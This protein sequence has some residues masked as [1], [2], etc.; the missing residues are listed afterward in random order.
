MNQIEKQIEQE[1][2]TQKILANNGYIPHLKQQ[3]LLDDKHRYKVI[4]CGRRFGKTVYAVNFIIQEASSKGGDYWFVAPTYRQAKEIAWRVFDQY[5]PRE[6]I[7]KKN[8]TEL[9]IELTN[10]ARISLKGA[11]NPDSLR[12]VG[13]NGVVLDEYAFMQPYAW[14]VISPILQDKKGWAI[15]IS[16][17]DGYNH[18]YDLYGTQDDDFKSFHYTSYDNPYLDPEEL[19][20]EKE[21]MSSER[22]AQEYE[23]E[24]M[25]RSGAVW[26]LFSRDIH[27][28][29]RSNPDKSSAVYGSI[30]FGFAIGHPTAFMLHE[31]K[32]TGEVC[33]FDGFTQEGLT[34]QSVVEQIRALSG[35]LLIRGIYCDTARPDLVR[36]LNEAGLPAIDARKDVELGIAKVEE[37]MM[38]DP[39]LGRPRW[40]ISSHLTKAVEQIEQYVWQEVRGEDG[41]FKQVPEKKNDDNC[42]AAGTKIL[43]DKGQI[44]IEELDTTYK[45]WTPFGW[46]KITS[47]GETG[48]QSVVDLFGTSATPNHKILTKR[49]FVPLDTLRYFDTIYL[50][51]K[52]YTLKEYH[53]GDTQIR[54]AWNIGDILSHLLIRSLEARQNSFTE[55]SGK[56]STEQYPK[57]ARY[58]ILTETLLTTVSRIWLVSLISNTANIIRAIGDL[59]WNKRGKQLRYGISPKR[60]ESGTRNTERRLGVIARFISRIAKPVSVSSRRHSRLEQDSVDSTV[61]C[62]RF[63]E[64]GVY[65]RLNLP[66]KQKRAKVYNLSTE[67]GCYFADGFLVSNCDALRY[68]LYSYTIPTKQRKRIIGYS[69]GDTITGYGGTPIYG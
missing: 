60:A 36:V 5:L 41:A 23:A 11:D 69:G 49:G 26:K 37:Y 10:G 43:T 25:K 9:S 52:P 68:F 38:V 66:R 12:G 22:F 21:R 33:T 31:I 14:E 7:N 15:F 24:F 28:V 8:E 48:E 2:R 19:N 18:F 58:I 40:T 32:S 17:P 34:P 57:I 56:V 51:E 3:E 42:F 4:R 29:P 53:I 39:A 62:L 30:D 63:E 55:Q 65:R 35:G 46:S 20:K 6:L 64:E 61:K 50:C 13:L 67:T 1:I 59:L 16:T 44:N 54:N 47:T 45:V 27:V